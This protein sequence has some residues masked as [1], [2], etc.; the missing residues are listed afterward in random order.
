MAVDLNTVQL[1]LEKFEQ[2]A[3]ALK[4][5]PLYIEDAPSGFAD[6]LN[7]ELDRAVYLFERLPNRRPEFTVHFGFLEDLTINAIAG[8]PGDGWVG[9]N[10]GVIRFFDQIFK[11]FLSDPRVLPHIGDVSG[12]AIAPSP[13]DQSTFQFL[14]N[15]H[16]FATAPVDEIRGGTASWMSRMFRAYLWLHEIGHVVHGHCT[17]LDQLRRGG[18]DK[19]TGLPIG[20]TKLSM[21]T[22]E[23]D[24]DAFAASQ[25]A[26]IR[27]VEAP[28]LDQFQSHL[29]SKRAHELTLV[30]F[31]LCVGFRIWD[32]YPHDIGAFQSTHHSA[33]LRLAAMLAV[34]AQTM[35]LE[36]LPDTGRIVATGLDL[37]ENAFGTMIGRGLDRSAIDAALQEDGW[38]HQQELLKEWSRIRPMLEAHVRAGSLAP[39][40]Y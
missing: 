16:L 7:E 10:V 9:L 38:G 26:Q 32:E 12:E 24:A 34:I 11:R 18:L 23:M 20:I 30:I 28:F 14:A 25:L 22:L 2:I 6:W 29:M 13:V 19:E 39:S 36:G 37:A 35:E 33:P 31:A 17:L 5:P 8:C 15:T 27:T 4:K 3:R 21:Q 1:R 40:Q